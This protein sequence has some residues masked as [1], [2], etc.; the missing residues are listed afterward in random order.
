MNLETKEIALVKQKVNEAIK[1]V[2][3]IK[4]TSGPTFEVAKNILCKITD[5]QKIVKEL[6]ESMTKPINDG[7]KKIREFFA[8]VEDNLKLANEELKSKMMVYNNKVKKEAEEDKENI[9]A[10]VENGDI[11]FEKGSQKIAKVDEKIE[12]MPTRKMRVIEIIDE[13]KIPKQYWVLDMI[14][15]RRDALAGVQ[16]DGVK[17]V[18]KEIIVSKN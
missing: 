17:V 11:D 12:S 9:V 18:E 2:D 10:K 3:N 8:P 1:G 7:L 13:A 4:I 6:R 15:I 14:T 5:T 16:I